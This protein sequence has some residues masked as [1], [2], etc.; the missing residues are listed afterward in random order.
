MDRR[1]RRN[2]LKAIIGSMAAAF[3]VAI[4]IFPLPTPD[5]M[6]RAT[7][8]LDVQSADSYSWLS[9]NELLVQTNTS[10]ASNPAEPWSGYFEVAD[11]RTGKRRRL[12]GL[13]AAMLQHAGHYD[14]RRGPTMF[15]PSPNGEWLLWHNLTSS[16]DV[17][18]S[19][20]IVTARM[21]GS[22]YHEWPAAM[23]LY[24]ADDHH[25]ASLFPSQKAPSRLGDMSQSRWLVYD[26]VHP[27]AECNLPY[28][29][30]GSSSSATLAP[31]LYAIT[32]STGRSVALEVKR[33]PQDSPRDQLPAHWD[34]IPYP[35]GATGMWSGHADV[36]G[37]RLMLLFH[38]LATP[39]IYSLL[40]G[41]TSHAQPV[42]SLY[43]YQSETKALRSVGH[44]NETSVDKQ[45]LQK[46][47]WLPDGKH[48]QFFYK[49]ALYS[50]AA[51]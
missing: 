48:V 18:T 24:W 46:A 33:Q 8:L 14:A 25:L 3:V 1:R 20:K 22:G 10:H 29:S 36:G 13:T 49:N 51:D 28:A 32:Q 19:D 11:L 44:V 27:D 50:V 37:K 42:A 43:L 34:T 9:S 4:C 17:R 6:Q 16:N 5:L 40:P 35:R 38:E 23:M 45:D 39:V 12:E 21:D 2:S 30:L 41:S 47:D 26:V 7:K 15:T 31:T